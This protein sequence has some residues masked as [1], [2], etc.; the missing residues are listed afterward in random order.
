MANC[1]GRIHERIVDE[2]RW[3]EFP[4]REV[5]ETIGEGENVRRGE[6]EG[7][8]KEWNR[9]GEYRRLRWRKGGIAER[10][11]RIDE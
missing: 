4:K 9:K 11:R 5:W 2:E 3:T 1:K 6:P 8:S 10:E 7:F